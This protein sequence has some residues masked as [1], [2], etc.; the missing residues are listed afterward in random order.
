MHAQ[1]SWEL[2]DRVKT[3]YVLDEK[4]PRDF[5]LIGYLKTASAYQALEDDEKAVSVVTLS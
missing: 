5:D 2:R 4:M 1:A 3:T